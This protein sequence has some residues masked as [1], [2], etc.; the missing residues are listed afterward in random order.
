MAPVIQLYTDEAEEEHKGGLVLQD[1]LTCV[2]AG[3][4]V[5]PL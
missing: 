3:P 4:A 2:K 1:K 5:L